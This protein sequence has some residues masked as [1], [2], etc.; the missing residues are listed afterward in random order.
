MS[1]QP[2]KPLVGHRDDAHVGFDG[3]EREVG[4]LRLGVGQAVEKGRFTYVGQSYD[5]A[6]KCHAI[7]VCVLKCKDTNKPNTKPNLFGFC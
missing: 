2:D 1:E 4:R 6:L 5:A 3:A 7:V